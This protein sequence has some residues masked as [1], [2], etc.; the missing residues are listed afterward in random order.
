MKIKVNKTALQKK[1]ERHEAYVKTS[2][3]QL[4]RK[5]ARIYA[6]ELANRTQPFSVGKGAGAKAKKLGEDAVEKGITRVMP[7]REYFQFIV[8]STESEAIKKRLQTLIA[9]NQ[10]QAFADA[11]VAVG[12][13]KE[14][15]AVSGDE[16]KKTHQAHRNPKTGRTLGIMRQKKMFL[17]GSE[18]DGYIS[19]VKKRVGLTKSAWADCARS[20]GGVNGDG[21]R[22]IPAF[23]KSKKHKTGGTAKDRTNGGKKP[24]IDMTN[25]LPW[26]S[27]ACPPREQDT[28]G[29]IARDK[30]IKEAGKILDYLAKNNLTGN[31]Q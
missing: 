23:A 10:W 13:W 21:A 7:R 24:A 6:V 8:D 27:T 22:G 11:M 3:P 29:K 18:V 28:A 1:L 20:I 31:M 5:Y 12:M 19:E 2:V 9:S 4:V 17:A 16:I 14:A 25:E 26:A 30:M 15:R